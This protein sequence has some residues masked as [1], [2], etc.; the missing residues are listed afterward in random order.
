MI[1]KNKKLSE[2]CEGS[3]L[4]PEHMA[5]VRCSDALGDWKVLQD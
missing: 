4:K 3:S 2:V 1:Q 5:Q